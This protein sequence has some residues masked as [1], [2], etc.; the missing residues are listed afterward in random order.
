VANSTGRDLV[1]TVIDLATGRRELWKRI[2][3]D[4]ESPTNQLLVAT[5]DLKY[6]AYP[7]FGPLYRGELAVTKST[8][9]W[10]AD[11]EA[12]IEK[13]RQGSASAETGNRP[14]RVNRCLAPFV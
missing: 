14:L 10:K 5:P 1:L 2:P 6:H 11:F 3:D 9:R 8:P 12:T 7:F 13:P 4:L